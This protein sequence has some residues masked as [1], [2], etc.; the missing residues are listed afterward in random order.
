MMLG[1]TCG[2]LLDEQRLLSKKLLALSNPPER[3]SHLVLNFS[4]LL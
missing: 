3:A 1:G 2:G 4:L